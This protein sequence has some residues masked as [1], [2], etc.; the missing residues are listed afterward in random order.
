MRQVLHMHRAGDCWISTFL[1][2][3]MNAPVLMFMHGGGLNGGDKRRVAHIGR[4]FA[5][6]GFITVC[7]NYRLSPA[8]THPAHI[9]DASAA[10]DWIYRN[11]AEYGGNPDRIF[12]SGGSAGGYLAALLAYDGRYLAKHNLLTDQIVAV[13]PISGLVDVTR[14]NR[15]RQRVVWPGDSEVRHSTRRRVTMPARTARPP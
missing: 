12:V 15:R 14:A 2:E 11:I 6:E 8:N 9:E 3:P 1:L 13:I 5:S 4:R 7:S 10:F